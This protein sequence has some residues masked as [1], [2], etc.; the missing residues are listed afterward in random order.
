MYGIKEL[1]ICQMLLRKFGRVYFSITFCQALLLFNRLSVTV[2]YIKIKHR[3]IMVIKPFLPHR[4]NSHQ[5][6][7]SIKDKPNSMQAFSR[8]PLQEIPGFHLMLKYNPG[9][10][11]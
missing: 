1:Q 5:Q 6:K 7:F 9:P 8:S 3:K 10:V 11:S 2:L 4:N